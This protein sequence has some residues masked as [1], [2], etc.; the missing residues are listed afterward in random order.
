MHSRRLLPAAVDVRVL[1]LTNGIAPE[2]LGGLQRY[3][4]ELATALAR[5]GV[6]VSVLTR[7]RSAEDPLREIDRDGVEIMRFRTPAKSRALY[8][9]GYPVAAFTAVWR[10]VRTRAAGRVLH[11]HFTLQGMALASLGRPFLHTFHAPVYREIA[12]ERQGSYRLPGASE[13]ALVAAAHRGETL[14]LSRAARI[15]TLSEFMRDEVTALSGR[16]ASRTQVVPG[17]VDTAH[18]APGEGIVHPAAT[19]ADPLLF[20]AR[21]LVPRTGVLELVR[22]MPRIAHAR[23]A[24]RLVLAGAGAL[25]GDVRREIQ[26]LELQHH[27][28]LSGRV[29]DE[30]LVRWY[31]SADLVVLP[32]QEL[33][34]FGLATAEA[35]ASG[36]P[37][38]GTP[39]G[40]TPELLT[41]L[42]PG[43]VAA[44]VTPD[45]IAD[46]V[47]ALA[48]DRKRLLA[49]ASQARARVHPAMSWPHI[50]Q[51]HLEVYEALSARST[52]ERRS[53]SRT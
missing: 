52:A 25:E 5:A 4:R 30:D 7:R 2:Q 47:I 43:L 28:H 38:L 12:S 33:E 53:E 48:S 27:V 50:V 8:A 20:C 35:L 31:R 41:D 40:A 6:D 9:V 23:P 10:T 26:H 36:T 39:A 3:V 49:L 24:V 22:A 46:A 18:F 45:A 17:G 16:A 13:R 1:L 44:D 11:S 51:R 42:D 34:G 21:R 14:M 29:S 37:V 32:T 19:D 15:I